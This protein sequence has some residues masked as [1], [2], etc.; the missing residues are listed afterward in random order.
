MSA[1]TSSVGKTQT[2]SDAAILSAFQIAGLDHKNPLHWWVLLVAFCEHHFAEPKSRPVEWDQEEMMKIVQYVTAIETEHPDIKGNQTKI[3]EK[4]QELDEHYEDVTTHHIAGRI[5]EALN[6]AK[7]LGLRY[8]DISDPFLQ[9]IR[10]DYEEMGVEWTPD[11][12]KQ[13]L[14][15]LEG[16]RSAL[17]EVKKELGIASD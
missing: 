9:K 14:D 17:K 12:E 8:P 2:K 13:N 3:A 15:M 6:P 4:I 1:I 7:N 11:I 16:V 10:A 5:R